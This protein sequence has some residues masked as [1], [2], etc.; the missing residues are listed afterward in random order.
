MSWLQ[1]NV[2]H[3]ECNT[4]LRSCPVVFRL[5]GCIICQLGEVS[6]AALSPEPFLGRGGAEL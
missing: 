4:L 2:L 6:V 3:S 5:F 1:I